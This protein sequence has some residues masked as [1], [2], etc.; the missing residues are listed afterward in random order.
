[1]GGDGSDSSQHIP[2]CF[3]MYCGIGSVSDGA[4]TRL[5]VVVVVA[6][7]G[8]GFGNRGGLCG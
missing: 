3:V 8:C 2:G 4:V 6:G 1:M 5:F 7:N